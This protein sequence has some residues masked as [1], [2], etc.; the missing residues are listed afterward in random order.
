MMRV[1]NSNCSFA[2]K[3]MLSRSL[4]DKCE[5]TPCSLWV[6]NAVSIS[7]ATKVSLILVHLLNQIAVFIFDKF[8][9]HFHAWSNFSG[10]NREWLS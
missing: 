1:E 7:I 4:W 3:I 2:D 8:A 5:T 10:F 6:F 9:F